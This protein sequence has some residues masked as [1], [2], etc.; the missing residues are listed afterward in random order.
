MEIISLKASF[1]RKLKP[2]GLSPLHLAVQSGQSEI[3]R[4]LVVFDKELIVELLVAK[5][6]MNKEEVNLKGNTALDEAKQLPQGEASSRIK[7]ILHEARASRSLTLP[8]EEY[9]LVDY[10]KSPE[11]FLERVFEFII[12]GQR[13]LPMKRRNTILVVAV[14]I[15]T[16]TFQASLQPPGGLLDTGTITEMATFSPMEPS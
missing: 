2:D 16:A 15:A 1:A 7:K 6:C 8:S 5:K 9:S 3:V 12:P 13:C 4:R 11:Q 10:L 14:L